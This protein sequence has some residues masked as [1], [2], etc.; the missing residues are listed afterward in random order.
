MDSYIIDGFTHCLWWTDPHIEIAFTTP[1]ERVR[2]QQACAADCDL[3][4]S[5]GANIS[6]NSS[7][8]HSDPDHAARM[9]QR[10]FSSFLKLLTDPYFSGRSIPS[11]NSRTH[12]EFEIK[13]FYILEIFQS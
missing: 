1:T 7:D 4:A 8:D 13:H 10:D 2:K 12:K 6:V 3:L 9:L 5:C 11:R